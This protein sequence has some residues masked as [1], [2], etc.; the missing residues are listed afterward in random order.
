MN[1]WCWASASFT[2]TGPLLD[3]NKPPF[4]NRLKLT[5]PRTYTFI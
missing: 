1:C 2:S 3:E 5:Q 4:A